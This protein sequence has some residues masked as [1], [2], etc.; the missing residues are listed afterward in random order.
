M[1][2]EWDPKK[3]A[4]NLQRHKVSFQEAA[5]VLGDPLGITVVDPDHSLDERRYLTVGVSDLGRSLIVAHADRG[6]RIRIISARTLT[7]RER[8]AY[9]EER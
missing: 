6:E 4:R 1:E 3:A 8:K 5:T 9:E 2:F 7:R